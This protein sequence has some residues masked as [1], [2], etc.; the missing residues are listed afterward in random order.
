MP[1]EVKLVIPTIEH[2]QQAIEY[3]QEHYDNGED[4][5]NGGSRFHCYESYEEW[6][7]FIEN[8]RNGKE[9]NWFPANT[10][11]G[12]CND[13][14]VGMIDILHEIDDGH[15]EHIGCGIRPS[16]RKKGYATKM[17]ALAL[18][19]C[20]KLKLKKIFIC[21]D[22]DS[23]GSVKTILNNGGILEKKFFDSEGVLCHSYFVDI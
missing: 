18:E 4:I 17:L 3:K 9:P 7:V 10:Y 8:L 20:K 21:C 13:K 6:L 16:E 14:I 22:E 12:M 11:F 2:K 15:R 1:N 19:E 23:I 5:L